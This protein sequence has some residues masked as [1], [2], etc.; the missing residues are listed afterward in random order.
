[1]DLHDGKLDPRFSSADATGDA[2]DD[3]TRCPRRCAD[4]LAF[5]GA[6][7][8]TSSRHDHRRRLDR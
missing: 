3:R 2:V 7:R 5:H 6:L 8:R 4:L 1:M